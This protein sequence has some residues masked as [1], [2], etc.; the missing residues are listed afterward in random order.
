MALLLQP[1]RV[2]SEVGCKSFNSTDIEVNDVLESPISLLLVV[3][4]CPFEEEDVREG[5]EW[6]TV[7]SM[8]R[9]LSADA[10]SDPTSTPSKVE[11]ED[12]D[13]MEVVDLRGDIFTFD[14][15]CDNGL[16]MLMAS[17]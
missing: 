8:A 16:L 10:D 9:D 1:N 2:S 4:A 13:G 7:L 11:N 3:A 5:S 6:V 14:D 15:C 17:S 12:S